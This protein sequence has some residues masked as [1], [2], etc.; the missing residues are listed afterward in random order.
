MRIRTAGRAARRWLQWLVVPLACAGVTP[1]AAAQ[2]GHDCPIA[3]G[4]PAAACERGPPV[5]LRA[6][7]GARAADAPT[8]EDYIVG[9]V[10]AD[11]DDDYVYGLPYARGASYPVLQ[12]YGS[13]FTHRDAEHFTV[14]FKMQVGTPVHAAREG[15][16]A[17]VEDGRDGS[18]GRAECG[19]FANF[20]V[21][22]HSDGT[23]GEYFHLERGS[24]VV[25][26]GERVQRGQMLARSGN[27]GF[28][29]APHLHFGVYRADQS[30][31]TRA[32]AVRF[33]THRGPIGAPRVGAR[34]LNAPGH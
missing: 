34:Y 27:T 17:L 22:L 1:P 5:F 19:A 12:A 14:D 20:I 26:P 25:A 28:T 8:R 24:S 31:T 4:D 21:I 11:H 15:V 3:S 32:V 9:A 18:C 30:G 2:A 6:S 23:T 10:D 13:R 33:L 7:G 29:T 16:V